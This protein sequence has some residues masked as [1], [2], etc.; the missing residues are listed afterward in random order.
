MSIYGDNQTVQMVERTLVRMHQDD[1][2][3]MQEKESAQNNMLYNT[4]KQERESAIQDGNY[5]QVR[6]YNALVLNALPPLPK[7]AAAAPGH[8][9]EAN[10][11]RKKRKELEKKRKDEYEQLGKSER[12]LDYTDIKNLPL[13]QTKESREKWENAKLKHSNLTRGET[14]RMMSNGDYSN[15]ENLDGVMRSMFAKESLNRM[16]QKFDLEN[17]QQM[18][19][20]TPEEI[21][22]RIKQEGGVSS[23][24]DPTLRLGLSLAQKQNGLYDD[25][26]KEWFRKLDEQMSAAVMLETLTHTTDYDN[27]KEM[28][29]RNAKKPLTDGEAGEKAAE[30]ISSNKAQQIQAAKRLLLMHLGRFM[31]VDN[32]GN[33]SDWDKPAAVALSHCSRVTMTLPMQK[34]NSKED[35]AAYQRMWN[36]IFYQKDQSNPAHDNRR[37]SSTHSLKVRKRDSAVK[38]KKVLFNFLGQ[39]GMNMAIGGLG[40]SGISGKTIL[41]DGSCGHFYSMFKEGDTSHYGAILMGM[42]SDSYGVTNQLGHTHDIKATGEKASSLGG[43]RTDEVGAKYGGRRCDLS[44][45]TPEQITGYMEKLE[46]AMKNWQKTENGLG[47]GDGAFVMEKLVGTPMST[48]LLADVFQKITQAAH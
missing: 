11:S 31:K 35:K 46:D 18:A 25:N 7:D 30:M 20:H 39:R 33:S 13:L 2:L 21:C 15:F 44:G 47:G 38:E 26:Q 6:S 5:R 48:E 8:V 36:S 1:T 32:D 45:L 29:K 43:Q 40:N 19:A 41:N 17:P 12:L 24:L 14:I 4:L 22:N 37:G 9:N 3:S 28:L 34:S 16:L 10:L 27:L 23:L 42:E